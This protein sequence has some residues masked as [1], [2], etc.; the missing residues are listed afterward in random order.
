MGAA[1][2][3]WLLE[4]LRGPCPLLA[5]LNGIPADAPPDPRFAATPAGPSAPHTLAQ[6]EAGGAAAVAGGGLSLLRGGLRELNLFKGHV[7]ELARK[8]GGVRSL[9][10]LRAVVV[11]LRVEGV[12]P[13]GAAVVGALLP[14]S[15]ATLTVLDLS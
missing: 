15:A 13:D 10:D 1:E 4:T 9:S 7:S 2:W 14:R 3:R 12:G 11:N 6:A 8:A 5:T